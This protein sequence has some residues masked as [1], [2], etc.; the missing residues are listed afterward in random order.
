[1]APIEATPLVEHVVCLCGFGVGGMVGGDVGA[2]GGEQV[3]ALAAFGYG[4]AE[5]GEGEGMF[6]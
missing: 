5:A 1:M 4:R 2:D 3:S 6:V